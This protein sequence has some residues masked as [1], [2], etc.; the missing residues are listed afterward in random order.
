M[1]K[2]HDL[3]DEEA[4]ANIVGMMTQLLD[5]IFPELSPG[6]RADAI[7]AATREATEQTKGGKRVIDV[8]RLR[9]SMQDAV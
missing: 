1:S 4:V 6:Q 3:T 9:R 8:H 5:A 7:A 2:P